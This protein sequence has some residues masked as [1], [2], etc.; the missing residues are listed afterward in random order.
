MNRWKPFAALGLLFALTSLVVVRGVVPALSSIETDFPNYFTAA[1]IVVKGGPVERLYDDSW[2]QA[3]T[4]QEMPGAP[5]KGKF[6]P[7]PP[8]TALLMVPLT[9]LEPLTALRV[10]VVAGILCLLCAIVLLARSVPL[11]IVDSA[12]VVLLAGYGL[13]ADLRFGQPYIE[14]STACILGYYA[15]R[16]EKPWLAGICLGLFVPVK[17]FPVILLACFAAF[18]QWRVVLG[19]IASATAVTLAGIAVLGWKVHAVFLASILGSHL[20]GHLGFQDPFAVSFQS[21]DS[22]FRRL[23]VFDAA[24]NPHPWLALAAAQM[25]AVVITKVALA[26]L[27]LATVFRVA[28]GGPARPDSTDALAGSLGLSGIFVLLVAPATASYHFLLLWLPVGLLLNIAVRRGAILHAGLLLA[29]YALI[30]FFPYGHLSGFAGQGGLTV[31]AYARLWLVAGL[32]FTA[33]HLLWKP[34]RPLTVAIGSRAA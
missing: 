6:G 26:T 8:P 3:Q 13:C 7:F 23:F 31:L 14:V 33:C 1:R 28:R 20:T 16:K 24:A 21:F 12:I 11:S 29:C 19:G 9:P 22:L 30:S 32:F 25:P 2:F 5:A 18:R 34:A 15:W 17:Y 27:A 10:T 4:R